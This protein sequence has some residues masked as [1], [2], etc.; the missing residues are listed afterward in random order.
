MFWLQQSSLLY[1]QCQGEHH[2]FRPWQ[3]RKWGG[4]GGGEAENCSLLVAFSI[5][6]G[7]D[8][9]IVTS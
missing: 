2:L 9:K 4:E 7:K 6:S 3:Q 1:P 8:A 5:P